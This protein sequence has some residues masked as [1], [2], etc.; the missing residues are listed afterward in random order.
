MPRPVVLLHGILGSPD[1]WSRVAPALRAA[2][3][4]VHALEDASTGSPRDE[5]SLLAPAIEN[6]G[7]AHLVG[8]SRGGT[9]ASWIAAERPDLAASLAI[10]ASP[11]QASEAF[12]AHFRRKGERE[13]GRERAA[14]EYLAHVPDED[15]PTH[16]L[17]R[18]AG[19]ALVV[20]AGDDPLYSPTHTLF[21]RAFLPYATFERVEGGHAFHQTAEGARRLVEMLLRHLAEAERA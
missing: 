9:V 1:D 5:A 12:R 19:R 3:F 16:A 15:F 7:P 13:G 17:R 10:V 2:G 21:W 8:H 14:Y 11:P 20:E 18:Y 4:E 6:V